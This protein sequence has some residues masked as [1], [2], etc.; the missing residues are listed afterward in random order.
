VPPVPV[1]VGFTVP[2]IFGGSALNNAVP[3]LLVS[4][5]KPGPCDKTSNR[6]LPSGYT[7]SYPQKDQNGQVQPLRGDSSWYFNGT[8]EINGARFDI[9]ASHN[10]PSRKEA[11]KLIGDFLGDKLKRA[12]ASEA[13]DLIKAEATRTMDTLVANFKAARPDLAEMDT[14]TI[15]RMILGT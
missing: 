13:R 4:E 9:Y 10:A 3:I 11:D 15:L 7:Q 6:P 5:G 14:Q 12:S 8:A 2:I 1:S